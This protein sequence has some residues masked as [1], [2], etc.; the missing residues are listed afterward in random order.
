MTSIAP[1]LPPFFMLL[2]MLRT[3]IWRLDSPP[4]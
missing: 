1:H 4:G 2:F 3:P